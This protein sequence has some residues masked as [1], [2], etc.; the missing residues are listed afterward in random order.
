MVSD[1]IPLSSP[2]QPPSSS[3]RPRELT[4]TTTDAILT[5]EQR[6]T[7]VD[8][9]AR[10]IKAFVGGQSWPKTR[11]EMLVKH[12]NRF[13]DM[14]APFIN[15]TVSRAEATNE[16]STLCERALRV[17]GMINMSPLSFQFIFN[18]CGIK[19]SE[20]SH[21]SL[22]CD[23]TPMELQARHWRLMCVVTPGI[24]YRDDTQGH[25]DPH[26]ISK[27]NVLVMQ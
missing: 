10:T 16:L 11:T 7:L 9:R 14:V 15:P 4:N 3:P 26:F 20:Q 6:N 5:P 24:T 23:L 21:H 17:S 13:K 8:Q 25:V 1:S 22:N 12:L 18:E 27:A 19:F 2:V